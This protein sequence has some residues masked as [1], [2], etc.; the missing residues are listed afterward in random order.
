MRS[1]PLATLTLTSFSARCRSAPQSGDGLALHDAEHAAESP[2]DIEA[3]DEQRA[4]VQAREVLRV[5]A[6]RDRRSS[7]YRES[8]ADA[9]ARAGS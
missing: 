9:N 6:L 8:R 3:D 2:A 1:R 5:A 4:D 7:R